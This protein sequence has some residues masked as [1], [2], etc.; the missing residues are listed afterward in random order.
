MLFN[1]AGF[2][3]GIWLV[4][5]CHTLP[6]VTICT[7]GCS[8]LFCIAWIF[9]RGIIRRGLWILL[10]F[11]FGFTWNAYQA[12]HWLQ[13]RLNPQ[14]IGKNIRVTGVIATL[15]VERSHATGFIF[16][17]EQFA[18]QKQQKY[19]Q[20]NWQYP[21][22]DVQI[23]DR[24]QFQL[25][26][27]PPHALT[28]PGGF[29]RQRW[30]WTQGIHATGYVVPK[31]PFQL[32]NSAKAWRLGRWRQ[33]LQTEISQT[34]SDRTAAGIITA[35]TIGVE[36]QLSESDWQVLRNTGTVH[37]VVIAGLHLGFM[38]VL[39]YFL[40]LRLWRCSSWLLLRFPAQQAASIA[41]IIFAIGYAALAGFGIPTQRAVIMII[42]LML[43]YLLY[44]SAPVWRRILIAFLI[45]LICQ[46]GAIFAAGFWLSFG[47]VA[48]IA[49]GL[50]ADW[51]SA[52]HWQQW[53]RMQWSLFLGL[54]PLTLYFFQQFS[55]VS[56]FAN[57]PA[58][59]W[60][61]WVIVPLCLLAAVT[62][63][64]YLPAGQGLF[65]LAAFLVM[66]MW[67]FLHWLAAM[68][69]V[70]WQHWFSSLWILGL[71]LAGA[72]WCLA[73]RAMPAR[74][75]G[76]IGFLPLWWLHPSHPPRGA[77]WLTVLDVGQGLAVVVQ[78][79]HHVLIYDTGPH[80][81]EGFDAGRDIVSPFLLTLGVRQVDTVV[82][83]HGDNDHSGGAE[84]ILSQW[85]VKRFMTSIPA[86]FPK[87]H[88]EFCV[89]GQQWQWDNVPFRVLGPAENSV[90]Q[91]NNSSCI[92]QIGKPGQKILL[93]GDIEAA[94]EKN[95][96]AQY[97]DK[98]QSKI[99]VVPHHGSKTSSTP[100]FLQAVRPQYALF[101]LGYINRF[102]F[103]APMVV[104]RYQALSAQQFFT[105]KNGAVTLRI[106]NQGA[107]K[108]R[109]TNPNRY[110][111]Q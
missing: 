48:W 109:L 87:H 102:H 33:A 61:G 94:T 12:N 97:G 62:S 6:S 66:P 50:N 52:P 96:V 85:Q 104:A 23:G 93:V 28:N 22:P 9:P 10:C 25:R 54:M 3:L 111:W 47:A 13:Q 29:N 103:P 7:L 88:A 91:D 71:A 63:S 89:A 15:P 70:I 95:L 75:L 100:E 73:P 105:A 101:S 80:L 108:I 76:I 56:L 27:K 34:V 64:I 40:M 79:A 98:L 4:A 39:A 51:R 5:Y 19:L 18:G 36:T 35:L 46:P 1:V 17:T 65:K 90:Y 72:A 110:F 32:L 2:A 21:H 84:S 60:I 53:L 41:A 74:W 58:I 11:A 59:P 37:L 67:H 107:V 57:L 30:L 82:V 78:T 38:V 77:V 55:L 42:I 14:W 45:V 44:Q 20:L 26:L 49:Y 24:W 86:M 69:H 106:S 16:K 99:V 43:S 31:Q 68:P 81:D 92:L 83:S 8:F